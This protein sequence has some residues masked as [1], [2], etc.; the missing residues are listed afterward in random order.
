MPSV[1]AKAAAPVRFGRFELRS[2]ERK[3][4]VD[5]RPAKLGARAFDVLVALVERRERIVHKNDLLDIVWPN[6][7]VEENNLQVHI[8]ALR[9]L[10]GPDAVSTIPGYGYRFTAALDEP[11]AAPAAGSGAAPGVDP[12]DG[13][14]PPTNLPDRLPSLIGRSDDMDALAPLLERHPLVSIVGAGGMGKTRLA[15]QLL[16]D[17]RKLHADGVFWVDLDGLSDPGLV[18]AAVAATVGV[19]AG[20]AGDAL[21]GL[22]AAVRPLRLLVALDNAEHLID[23]VARVA[24]SLIDGAP[25]L[26]LLVTSQTPLGLVDTEQV[27]R[28]GP[29]AVPDVAL[30]LGQAQ[31]FGAVALFAERARAADRSFALSAKNVATVARIC[32]QLDG[33][34]LAIELAASRVPLL[35]LDGLASALGER[36]RVL[37]TAKRDAPPRQQTLRA[38]LDWSYSL[39]GPSEQAMFRRLGVFVGGFSLEMARHVAD[40]GS[41]GFDAHDAWA[42]VDA[43]GVLV[44]R[45]LVNADPRHVTAGPPRYRLLETPRAYALQQLAA[46]GELEACRR[47]HAI[48]VLEHFSHAEAQLRA[49]RIGVDETVAELEADLDNGREALA[50]AIEHDA[51]SALALAVSLNLALR[52]RRQEERSIWEATAMCATDSVPDEVHACWAQRCA[53]FWAGRKPALSTTWARTAVQLYRRLGQPIGLYLAL[54]ELVMSD[55]TRLGEEQVAALA[56]MRAL[57]DAAWPA[58][59]RCRGAMAEFRASSTDG[60]FDAAQAAA[61]RMLMLAERSGNSVVANGTLA[62]L[63]DLALARGQV[64]QAVAHGTVLEQRLRGTRHQMNLAFARVNLAGALLAQGALARA[65]DMAQAGW[66]MAATFDVREYWADNLALLA[67]LE[68]RPR[69]AA[70]LRGYGDALYAAIGSTRQANEAR[71]AEQARG[72]ARDALGEHEV[73]RLMAEGA[74]LRDEEIAALAFGLADPGLAD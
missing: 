60:D 20:G 54:A 72:L 52:E 36:L 63:A 59:V 29:L 31:H 53:H 44:D 69:D 33:M 23:E 2:A 38:A 70:R 49:G 30:P 14:A 41:T 5:G 67:A 71:A 58:V 10:L 61:Q 45:S 73:A 40:D 51:S 55:P 34:A 9:K 28:L 21:E 18:A 39:L 32:A 12:P 4:L 56:E 48:A 47:R 24:R 25:W 11:A 35:G 46:A 65:R 22:V 50:W 37:R 64:D 17:R 7:V 27:Y 3:L 43:L 8:W 57:D 62:N 19:Q 15:Q 26:R 74:G 16:H 6:V 1:P 68:D 42:A 13:A 66:P